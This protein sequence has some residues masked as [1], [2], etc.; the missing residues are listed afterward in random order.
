MTTTRDIRLTE[1]QIDA[2]VEAADH[3]LRWY[4]RSIAADT[5]TYHRALDRKIA[6]RD[7]LRSAKHDLGVAQAAIRRHHVDAIKAKLGM[8]GDAS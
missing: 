8:T 4:D 2:L 6:T 7:E 5:G 3:R 1:A